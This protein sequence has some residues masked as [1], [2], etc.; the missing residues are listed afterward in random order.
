MEYSN[1]VNEL[2][3]QAAAGEASLAVGEAEAKLRD[4]FPRDASA[5]GGKCPNEGATPE[6][7]GS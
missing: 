7:T 5:K 3:V 6:E 2:R 1:D 4:R